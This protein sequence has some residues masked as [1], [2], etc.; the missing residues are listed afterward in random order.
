[1]ANISDK[2]HDYPPFFNSYK[3]LD[4]FKLIFFQGSRLTAYE[5]VYEKIPATLICDSAVSALM[6]L[7]V[8]CDPFKVKFK[9]LDHLKFKL[10]NLNVQMVFQS[11]LH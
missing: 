6:S 11:A 8:S 1:M 7:K 2:I 5:L 10:S 9:K 4:R 3:K